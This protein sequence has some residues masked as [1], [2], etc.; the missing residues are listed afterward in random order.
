MPPCIW[1]RILSSVPALLF[2]FTMTVLSVISKVTHSVS[3]NKSSTSEKSS[4]FSIFNENG[5]ERNSSRSNVTL[6]LYHRLKS[7]N[8]SSKGQCLKINRPSFQ[9]MNRLMFTSCLSKLW[10]DFLNIAWVPGDKIKLLLFV[11]TL[12]LPCFNVVFTHSSSV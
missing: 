2:Y 4:C 11:S 6:K 8:T 9:P 5:N 1:K 3:S 10:S 12:T 7:L